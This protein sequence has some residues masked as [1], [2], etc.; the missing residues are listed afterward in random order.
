MNK[1]AKKYSGSKIATLKKKREQEDKEMG[2]NG[3]GEFFT[4]EI[5]TNRFR[6]FPPHNPNDTF[7][8]QRVLWW[9]PITKEDGSTGMRPFPHMRRQ[10]GLGVDLAEEYRKG[11]EKFLLD[12]DDDGEEKVE[13]LKHWKTGLKE[14]MSWCSYAKKVEN[15]EMV[16]E[17]GILDYNKTTRDSMDKVIATEEEDQEIDVDPFS[18]PVTGHPLSI[19]IVEV[20]KGKKTQKEYSAEI[21]RKAKAI[22]LTDEHFDEFD[23]AKPLKEM[24]GKMSEKQFD[25]YLEALENFDEINDFNYWGTDEWQE[26]LVKIKAQV[27]NDEEDEKSKKDSKKKSDSGK[28]KSAVVEDDEEEEKPKVKKKPV[29]V[30]E[31][32]E[33]DEEEEDEDDEEEED[34]EEGIDIDK[35]DRKELKELIIQ[36]KLEINVKKSWSD[37][38]IRD[39]IRKSMSDEE[40]EDEEEEEDDDEEI[41]LESIKKKISKGSK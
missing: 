6:I 36:E 28:K 40:E 33:D 4:L 5:G 26:I 22:P 41:T 10:I 35:L 38:D 15:D 30:E 29:T 18:D 3:G 2:Y 7:D 23:S 25:D 9:L 1:F 21:P 13:K 39:A 14:A 32:E 24:F 8:F 31:D 12:S 37:D 34:D 20:K 19:K 11:C 17:L 27:G 16:G